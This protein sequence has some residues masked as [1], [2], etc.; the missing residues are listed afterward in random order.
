MIANKYPIEWAM[1]TAKYLRIAIPEATALAQRNLDAI[2]AIPVAGCTFANVVEALESATEPL[3]Y[4]WACASHL[5]AVVN[6][7]ELRAVYNEYLPSVTQ[8]YGNIVL[9]EE[10]WERVHAIYSRGFDGLTPIQ[11]RLLEET[12]LDFLENGANLPADKKARLREIKRELAQKTQK[13]SENVLD[14]TDAWEKIIPEENKSI[15]EGLPPTI[16]EILRANAAQKGHASAYRLTL[17]EAIYGPAMRY[18]EPDTLRRELWS[19]YNDLGHREPYENGVLIGEI[20]ALRREKAR[21][22]GRENFPDFVLSRRMAK[23]GAGALNFTEDLHGRVLPHFR[24]EITY[25]EAFKRELTGNSSDRLEPW[26]LAYLSEKLCRKLYNF[27]REELRPYFP[28]D[29]VLSG[30]FGILQRLYGITFRA[31]PTAVGQRKDPKTIPVWH[32]DVRYYDVL[33][34]D[35][36]LLGSFYLDL[37]PRE[38]KRSGAWMEGVLRNGHRGKNG[39]WITPIGFVAANLTPATEADPSLLTHYEVETLFHEFGHLMHH[40]MG[41]VDY[42]SL[43]GTNVA[44]DFVELP[45]QILENWVWEREALDMFARHHKSQKPL[46]GELFEKMLAARNHLIATTIMRQLS[47]Q[48]MDL[49]LHISYVDDDLDVF[50]DKSI[51]SYVVPYATKPLSLVRHFLHLFSSS[52]GYAAAYYSYKWSEVLDADAFTRFQGEGIFNG[53]VANEFR[54]TILE[55]GNA[56]PPDVLYYKFMGRPPSLNALLYRYGLDGKSC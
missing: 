9:N 33:E 37:F 15:L 44:C 14:A 12:H 48:K 41:R 1:F 26:Q 36:K 38:G 49:D 21:L 8:F 51:S 46:P 13:Y 56:E 22:L 42:G 29:A 24:E 34:G 52:T 23:T 7:D 47:F 45:S 39:E 43:N 10:L 6:G 32:G 30:L 25:L 31:L 35:G 55:R 4:V 17:H 3:D 27:D 2:A 16:L 40:L 11:K 5:D 20:L 18:L 50:I 53:V 54:R 28:L 19:A